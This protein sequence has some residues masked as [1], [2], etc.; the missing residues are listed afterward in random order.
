MI[1]AALA[2]VVDLGRL[3]GYQNTAYARACVCRMMEV[4]LF[5]RLPS[6]TAAPAA[7]R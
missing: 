6:A 4:T 7:A 2:L 3:V 1:P 5:G